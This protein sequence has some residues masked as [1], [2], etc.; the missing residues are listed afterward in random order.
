MYAILCVF[1]QMLL[2]RCLDDE[3]TLFR[4]P[5]FKYIEVAYFELLKASAPSLSTPPL[6]KLV[7]TTDP[8][9]LETVKFACRTLYFFEFLQ[10]KNA[11]VLS[12]LFKRP[13]YIIK[14]Y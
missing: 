6:P 12:L 8:T 2:R 9:N 13:R 4:G 3:S 1:Q 7:P 14:M 5:L 10:K 11:L